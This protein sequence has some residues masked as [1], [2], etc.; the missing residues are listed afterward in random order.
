MT[1]FRF[2]WQFKVSVILLV[3]VNVPFLLVAQVGM[4]MIENAL[5]TEKQNKLLSITHVLDTMLGKGGF[6]EILKQNNALELDREE[7]ITILNRELTKV[8]DSI[9]PEGS[10]LAVGYYSLALDAIVAYAPSEEY[11]DTVGVT[12][13]EEH[14]GR[15]VMRTK[16]PAV[17]HGTMVRG[18]IMNAM[19][20]L[21]RNGTVIG[22]IWANELE[23]DVQAQI[24]ELTFE[25]QILLLVCFLF[26]ASILFFL[27]MRTV[28]DMNN[29]ID[30]VRNLQ[31]D[32]T[33][34]I[35]S[36]RGEFGDV[37]TSIND[38][39]E[40]IG[41]ATEESARAISVLQSV[42]N[43]I[44]VSIAVYD[45]RTRSVIY[46]NPYTTMLWEISEVETKAR[47]K[48]L[49][50]KTEPSINAAQKML[51]LEK[52]EPNFTVQ[53]HE[54][55][56]SSIK[57]DFLISDRLIHWHDGRVVH[58]R[59][60]TD[61]T[62]RKALM[63]AESAN[64]AQ[65]DFL[66]RM[67]H[68]IRTPM[69]G[70]LGMTRLA[71]HENPSEKQLGYLNKIQSSATLLL[72]IIN[73]ILDFSR[74][75]AGAM[76]IENK[77]FNVHETIDKV[78]ELI[79]PRAEENKTALKLNIN[80]NV[81]QF[82]KGD[83]LRF[84]QILLNLL[85]NASKFTKNGTITLASWAEST[86]SG[87]VFVHCKISDTGIGMTK[88][89]IGELFKPFSQADTST[90]RRFGGTGLGLSIC[91]AFVELMGGSISVSSEEGRGSIFS[92]KVRFDEYVHSTEDDL[93]SIGPW[94][95]MRYDDKL[96]LLVED[97]F[98][99]QEVALAVLD[100]LGLKTDVANDG[101]EGVSMFLE[102]DYDVIFMD[103]RMPVM[104][105]IDATRLIRSSD[106]TDARTVPIIAMTANAMDEDRQ[107]SIAAGLNAHVSKP[108]DIDELKRTLYTYLVS[109]SERR[110]LENKA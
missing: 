94:T 59:V 48:A 76:T 52:G 70:V 25:T 42:M 81:P 54:E 43:N 83:S 62:A 69:N 86:E 58:L 110:R 65:R 85:G 66:A 13:D 15:E 60:C 106:K 34:R 18:E 37:V 61:T 24:S 88:E 10:G 102:K 55:H 19:Y 31:S 32:L 101:K 39:A 96:A 99:N 6:T 38:M 50:N 23:T 95:D 30:G 4:N 84:S 71:I 14:P 107:N 67:S 80:P 104:N 68:E 74:I 77:P 63:A 109:P 45:P 35:P 49:Y 53:H 1:K 92:F 9:I 33:Y 91:K 51:F 87:K 57:K 20:P 27:S 16:D 64:Q 108:I 93:V 7:K 22:Y 73:D 79:L 100:G 105:G 21:E 3:L 97:N 36:I 40:N 75:E 12:I 46:A 2:S 47:Y 103:M 29:V 72:G 26:T 90:S 89:Q 56:I 28:R 82:V 78:Q 5:L 8:A 98:I 41:K 44:E 11:K 17:V